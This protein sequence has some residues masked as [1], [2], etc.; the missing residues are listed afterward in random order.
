MAASESASVLC[1]CEE[2]AA[3]AWLGTVVLGPRPL[4]A[5]SLSPHLSRREGMRFAYILSIGKLY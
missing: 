2:E 3:A 1:L 5:D 4:P